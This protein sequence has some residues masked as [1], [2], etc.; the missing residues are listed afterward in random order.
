MQ[1][2]EFKPFIPLLKSIKA[3][4][5]KF[6]ILGNHDYG[7]YGAWNSREKSKNIPTLKTIKPKL[8]LNLL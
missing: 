7:D 8:V 4:D 1:I 5:G 3:K 6:S 2:D